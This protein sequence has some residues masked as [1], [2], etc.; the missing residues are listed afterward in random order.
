MGGKP[1]RRSDYYSNSQFRNL[2][3]YHEVFRPLGID[4]HCAVHIP[5]TKDQ[6]IFFGL[7][8]NG[9]PDYTDK[10][11]FLLEAAQTQLSSA[12]AIART[13]AQPDTDSISIERLCKAGLTPRQAETLHWICQGKSNQEIATLMNIRL[14][15]VKDH[16]TSIFNKT[17]VDNRFSTI[18]WARHICL[19]ES[20]PPRKL[21]TIPLRS[22]MV[23]DG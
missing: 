14:Y 11:L 17:G 18:V 7:E 21:A 15:T 3:V 19:T 1:V 13:R 10:E 8:R 9:G 12:H 6:I 5:T 22:G 2:D 4:N 20:R 23:S 16:I